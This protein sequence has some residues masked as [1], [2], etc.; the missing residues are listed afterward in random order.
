LTQLF[1][2]P[3]LNQQRE[4]VMQETAQRRAPA[5]RRKLSLECKLA[6]YAMATGAILVT[7]DQA[8]AE[9]I[10]SGVV[11]QLVGDNT[12]FN[13]DLNGD[14]TTDFTII[15]SG[16]LYV[17]APA[18]NA[19]VITPPD[20]AA[21]NPFDEISANRQFGG[22]ARVMAR[23]SIATVS[24]MSHATTF[25][26]MSGPW[27]YAQNKFLGLRFVFPDGSTHYG[28]ARM[29][30]VSFDSVI[31]HDWAYEDTPDKPI[32]AGDTIGG[33]PAPPPA[34]RPHSPV[35]PEPS[36][37][38]LLARGAAG[39]ETHLRNQPCPSA[40]PGSSSWSAGMPPIGR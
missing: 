25:T 31:V 6:A 7:Q 36:P 33:G 24:T 34:A 3:S 15:N 5:R 2:E 17:Q 29:S 26:V 13:L 27:A 16:G 20:A 14:G 28:W 9:I 39:V 40:L 30:V 4:K 37:L 32:L 23:S 18:D 38:A 35:T 8:T 10:Y 19:V 11:D 21:L 22:G 12:S 1:V